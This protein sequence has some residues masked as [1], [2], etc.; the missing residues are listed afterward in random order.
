MGHMYSK[1]MSPITSVGVIAFAKIPV[2]KSPRVRTTAEVVMGATTY[3]QATQLQS[4]GGDTDT[5]TGGDDTPATMATTTTAY[6]VMSP[7]QY[8]V[9]YLMIRRKNSVGYMD[10]MR[11]KYPLTNIDCVKNLIDVM[12]LSEKENL[13]TMDF[14][15]LWSDLWQNSETLGFQYKQEEK[16][17]RE[18]FQQ[19]KKGVT[20]NGIV[21]SI[22]SLVAE[23]TTTWTEPEWGFPKGRR[24]YKET[25]IACA[26]REF[27]EETGYSRDMLNIIENVLPYDEIFTGSNYKSYKHRYFLANVK[28]P[29]DAN[30]ADANY[31]IDE[32]GEI[33]WKTFEDA[34]DAIRPYNVERKLLLEKVNTILNT[35]N[36]YLTTSF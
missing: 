33:A 24:N 20:V 14:D 30:C 7:Q 22:D 1:C 21:A 15:F 26:I 11:G 10:F 28:T 27:E 34:I 3:A 9:K 17:S 12:T 29:I 31:Q 32:V 18:K 5:P 6:S 13:K 35:P 4:G 8:V 25:D 16:G 2:I 36:Y 23:S 19:L